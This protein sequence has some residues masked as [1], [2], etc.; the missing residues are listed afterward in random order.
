VGFR[1]RAP[2]NRGESKMGSKEPFHPGRGFT[3]YS[4]PWARRSL[5]KPRLN[6]ECPGSIC[7]GIE[8]MNQELAFW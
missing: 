6:N 2:W 3:E 4:Q 7:R 5:N 8:V 1:T